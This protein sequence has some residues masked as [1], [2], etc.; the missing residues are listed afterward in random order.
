[1]DGASLVLLLLKQSQTYGLFSPWLFPKGNSIEFVKA[2]AGNAN[3]SHGMP[4][5]CFE[6]SKRKGTALQGPYCKS[7]RNIT[8]YMHWSSWRLRNMALCNIA[9]VRLHTTVGSIYWF[10]WLN[11]RLKAKREGVV[12]MMF[13]AIRPLANKVW[14]TIVLLHAWVFAVSL[15]PGKCPN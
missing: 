2:V 6:K 4:S 11:I 12:V 1:M 9:R 13:K 8:Q 7:R 15:F 14:P 10:R 5:T 3:L